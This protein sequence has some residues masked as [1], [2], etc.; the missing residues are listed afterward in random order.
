MC[1]APGHKGCEQRGGCGGSGRPRYGTARR[2]PRGA[3]QRSGTGGAAGGAPTCW[4]PPPLPYDAPAAET[5][6]KHPE[7][8]VRTVRI[9]FLF[10]VFFSYQ[11]Y[12]FPYASP[13]SALLCSG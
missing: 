4:L 7:N 13:R 1:A 10:F 2:A 6:W 5:R 9:F 3:A 8:E 11:Y 12:L